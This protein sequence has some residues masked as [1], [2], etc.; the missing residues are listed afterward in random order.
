MNNLETFEKNISLE[1]K[2]KEL[3]L[4]ALTHRSYLNEH[5]DAVENNERLEFLG[6]AVLELIISNYLFKQYPD[7]PEGDLTS[8]RS[9]LVRTDSLAQTARNLGVGKYLRL[10]KGEE[11]TGGREKDYLLANTFEAILGA[12]YLDQGYDISEKFVYKNLVPKLEEIVANRLDIDSKT[13][14]QEVSQSV[15]KTTP[16]YEVIEEKGPDHDKIFTVVVKI[17]GKV[18]GKGVGGSKQKAEEQA[19]TEGIKY[20]EKE[21]N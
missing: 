4:L 7:R 19:A 13:K 18:I 15:Y 9:A 14:I 3:L 11:D 16:I 1:F 12:I 21:S 6:D 10:S 2:N 5:K 17:N 8:F 20:I